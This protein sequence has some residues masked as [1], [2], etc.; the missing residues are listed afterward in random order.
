MLES[1]EHLKDEKMAK[2]LFNELKKIKS[3]NRVADGVSAGLK[4]PWFSRLAEAEY[5]VAEMRPKAA[6]WGRGYCVGLGSPPAHAQPRGLAAPAEEERL[7][8]Y[9]G[10]LEMRLMSTF[11]SGKSPKLHK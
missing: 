11:C 4:R 9:H 1:S 2:V 3:G 8:K 6:S 7:L 10:A 5:Q